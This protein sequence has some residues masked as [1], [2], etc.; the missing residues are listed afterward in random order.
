MCGLS[1]NSA[2]LELLCEEVG[3]DGGE[4]R[5]EWRQKHTHVADVNGDV[6]EVHHV[7][8]EGRGDHQTCAMEGI[9]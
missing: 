7:I 9:T 2:H 5:E 8:E 1:L 4:R 6:E 3:D